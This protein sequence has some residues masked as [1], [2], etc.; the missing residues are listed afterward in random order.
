MK[1]RSLRRARLGVECLSV[2]CLLG[3]LA[4]FSG[5]RSGNRIVIGSKSFSEQVILA[6]MVAQQIERKTDLGVDRR[7]N[8]GGTLIC[9][10]ALKAGE[11]DAYV[12]YSGTALTAILKIDVI[13][14]PDEVYRRVR[15]EY[16]RFGLEW[17]DPLGFNNTHV[18]LVRGSD[19]RRRSIISGFQKLQGN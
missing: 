13:S 5:C 9:D 7:F 2:L 19:A 16:G 3:S 17:L 12:E 10:R 15:E 1:W 11:L 4:P 14:D 8:L 18:I 6:E